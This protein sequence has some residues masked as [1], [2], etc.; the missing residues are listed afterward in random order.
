M[1]LVNPM[2]RQAETFDT[3]ANYSG[4]SPQSGCICSGSI[5]AKNAHYQGPTM[6]VGYCEHGIDNRNANMEQAYN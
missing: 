2:G 3:G 4:I 6:C 1:K 5:E